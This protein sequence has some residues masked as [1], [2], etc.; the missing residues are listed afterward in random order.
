MPQDTKTTKLMS[1]LKK[2]K[3]DNESL[4]RVYFWEEESTQLAQ[5]VNSNQPLP[6]GVYRDEKGF[7]KASASDTSEQ[8]AREYLML[9]QLETI[10]NCVVFFVALVVVSMV[11]TLLVLVS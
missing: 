11:I 5:L 9:Q 10:K 8:A 4:Q 1:K 3:N 6:A 2:I 7:Y